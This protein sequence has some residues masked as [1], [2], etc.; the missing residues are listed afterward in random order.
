LDSICGGVEVW[1]WYRQFSRA[2]TSNSPVLLFHWTSAA[3][4]SL[5][6]AE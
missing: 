6:V 5:V 4:Y 3:P 2:F 1:F